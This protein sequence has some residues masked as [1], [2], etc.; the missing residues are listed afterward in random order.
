MVNGGCKEQRE[1][2]LPCL[3]LTCNLGRTPLTPQ[4]PS[5]SSS[6][7]PAALSE[8]QPASRAIRARPGSGASCAPLRGI[9]LRGIPPYLEPVCHSLCRQRAASLAKELEKVHQE[10][11]ASRATEAELDAL[12]ERYW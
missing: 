5:A 11:E 8:R 3:F 9:P 7:H 1:R 6:A 4:S 10:L 2:G 12:E